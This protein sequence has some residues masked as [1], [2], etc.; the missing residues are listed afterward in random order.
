MMVH[1]CL[2]V[3]TH[4]DQ[5]HRFAY[6]A[7]KPQPHCLQSTW[8]LTSLTGHLNARRIT[9]E[10]KNGLPPARDSTSTCLARL[11]LSS[12][13]PTCWRDVMWAQHRCAGKIAFRSFSRWM[14]LLLALVAWALFLGHDDRFCMPSPPS[15]NMADEVAEALRV[16]P[17]SLNSLNT[18]RAIAS[19]SRR[20]YCY[21]PYC[22]ELYLCQYAKECSGKDKRKHGFICTWLVWRKLAI[23]LQ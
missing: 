3:W 6:Q 22:T 17:C 9:A 21:P 8:T 1:I 23:I 13:T 10:I 20:A 11:E 19:A 18:L 7:K 14:F 15:R 12:G 16:I 2:H 4:S 5:Q